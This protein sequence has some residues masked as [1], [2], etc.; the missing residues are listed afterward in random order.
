[1]R[2]L[3][4]DDDADDIRQISL[5]ANYNFY[6]D[7]GGGVNA[8]VIVPIINAHKWRKFN[9]DDD[10]YVDKAITL[11]T[12]TAHYDVN[13][14]VEG[15][16]F[17]RYCDGSLFENKD[18]D[19]SFPQLFCDFT[20]A[21]PPT[22]SSYT[23]LEELSVLPPLIMEKIYQETA[24]G[25]IEHRIKELK[26]RNEALSDKI[27]KI[28]GNKDLAKYGAF[29]LEYFL[30]SYV[31]QLFDAY[32]R[33]ADAQDLCIH[34]SEK[35]LKIGGSCRNYH[36]PLDKPVIFNV[37]ERIESFDDF[38]DFLIE[39]ARANDAKVD[40]C[41]VACRLRTYFDMKCLDFLQQGGHI[42]TAPDPRDDESFFSYLKENLIDD[43][44]TTLR[45]MLHYH[46]NVINTDD[47]LT[48][49]AETGDYTNTT[50]ATT[51]YLNNFLYNRNLA[52]S[53]KIKWLHQIDTYDFTIT[54]GALKSSNNV[55][56]RNIKIKRQ[57]LHKVRD[58]L[59]SNDNCHNNNYFGFEL[60][61]KEIDNGSYNYTDRIETHVFSEETNEYWMPYKASN[62]NTVKGMCL[63]DKNALRLPRFDDR[64]DQ[65]ESFI[66]SHNHH[67][68][69]F[70]GGLRNA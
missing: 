26:R 64:W 43:D 70:R 45:A 14:W 52:T 37:F 16:R 60:Y 28:G 21:L 56:S 4:K 15:R 61:A 34:R 38:R 59:K 12:L 44:A 36:K 40:D 63:I 6:W 51:L 13:F 39:S 11:C 8:V 46:R 10:D 31:S 55:V 29:M 20:S 18:D 30:N 67:D 53:I 65:I 42:R 41:Y 24:R 54:Q 33:H 9:R 48:M 58:I 2:A 62:I 49:I 22:G 66:F 27:E 1:M 19:Y 7:N 68:K 35:K 17:S 57:P 3:L 25:R 32:L 23:T 50:L 47:Y 5:Y 69:V